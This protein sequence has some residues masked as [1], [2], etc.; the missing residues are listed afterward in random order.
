MSHGEKHCCTSICWLNSCAKCLRLNE[1]CK[2][3]LPNKILSTA[4][5]LYSIPLKI[6]SLADTFDFLIDWQTVKKID[7]LTVCQTVTTIRTEAGSWYLH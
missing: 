5:I 3:N 2:R 6:D 7:N 1:N 4:D